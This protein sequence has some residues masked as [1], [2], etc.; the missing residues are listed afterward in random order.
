MAL[1]RMSD[2]EKTIEQ[3]I[4]VDPFYAPAADASPRL[5]STFVRLHEQLLPALVHEKFA[6][7]KSDFDQKQ[8]TEAQN[9]SELVLRLIK[10]AAIRTPFHL[11]S[12]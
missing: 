11:F 9:G 5:V 1:A 8:Y 12:Y 10:S 4:E 7:A 3:M 6:K 2:A